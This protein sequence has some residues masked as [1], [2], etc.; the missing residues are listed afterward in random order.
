MTF[1]LDVGIDYSGRESAMRLTGENA[2]LF[3]TQLRSTLPGGN[4][5]HH[6]IP[7]ATDDIVRPIIAW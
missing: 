1:D 7:R 6:Y 3:D 5:V 4:N 2:P